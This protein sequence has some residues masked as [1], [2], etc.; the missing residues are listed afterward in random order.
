[1]I[2]LYFVYFFAIFIPCCLFSKKLFPA[3]Y[4]KYPI[5]KITKKYLE[6]IRF[7]RKWN[8]LYKL[9]KKEVREHG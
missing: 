4:S 3:F 1:M 2:I 7:T 5:P 6:A 8:R 9:Q